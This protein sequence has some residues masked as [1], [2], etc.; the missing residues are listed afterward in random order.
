MKYCFF[1]GAFLLSFALTAAAQQKYLLSPMPG[2]KETVVEATEFGIFGDRLTFSCQPNFKKCTSADPGFDDQGHLMAE[3]KVTRLLYSAQGKPAGAYAVFHNI[4]NAIKQTGGKMLTHL[5]APQN[6][7]VYLVDKGQR[8][9]WIVLDNR[10]DNLFYIAYIE[11]KPME[12]AIKTDPRQHYLLSAMP[13]YKETVAEATEFGVFGD[14]LTFFCQPQFKRCTSADPGFDDQGHL[15]AEGKVTRLLYSA[16]GNPAGGYA[17]FHNVDNAIKQA[18][19]KMLTYLSAPKDTHVYLVDKG[20]H[21]TWIVLDNRVDNLFYI[22]YIES[23][24]MEQVVKVNQLEDAIQ[25]SGFATLYI[26]FENNKFALPADAAPTID[27]IVNLL[28]KQTT[29]RLS[30]EGHT[31]NVGSAA[32]NQTLSQN[33]ANSV[34][35]AIVAGGIDASRLTAKGFGSTVPVADNR[36]DQGRAKNRRVE[37]VKAK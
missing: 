23:K 10:A 28:K 32:S 25:K 31:D 34:M 13:G 6:A 33:R 35:Q 15:T 3:G 21:K 26:N 4:D 24:P 19:G 7:H 9:T 37:L 36:T 16:Q 22:A 18:G 29:W 2:Y 14:R 30:V 11:S 20:Q 5:S 17:V 8:K 12:Q 1:I 27:E